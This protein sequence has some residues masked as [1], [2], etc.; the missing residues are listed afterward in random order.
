M[1]GMNQPGQMYGSDR[2]DQMRGDG[3][4][5]LRYMEAPNP[6]LSAS[7]R[8]TGNGTQRSNEITA[9]PRTMRN[10]SSIDIGISGYAKLPS[11]RGGFACGWLPLPCRR[12]QEADIPIAEVVL[13]E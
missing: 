7:P 8:I 12:Q 5:Q 6:A 9:M 1:S 3:T 13:V 10:N 2:I 4:N 11:I